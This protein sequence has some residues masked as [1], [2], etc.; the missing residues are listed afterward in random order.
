MKRFLALAIALLIIF[1]VQYNLD[2]GRKNPM[3]KFTSKMI[4]KTGAGLAV[5]GAVYRVKDFF[6]GA[7]PGVRDFISKKAKEMMKARWAPDPEKAITLHLTNGSA[8]S[9]EFVRETDKGYTIFWQ[10][11]EVTFYHDEIERVERGE[12]VEA[13]G[14]YLFDPEVAEEW[15]YK[16]TTAVIMTN[17]TAI[18]A[19]VT[20]VSEESVSVG[21]EVE[22]GGRIEQDLERKKVEY[23]LAKPVDNKLSRD[24]ERRLKELF[25]KMS[26]YKEGSTTIVTD[27]YITWVRE[28]R[29]TIRWAFRN[30][31]LRFFKLFKGRE[32][33]IQNFVVI[34]DDYND[35]V[36]YAVADGV[37]G[38]MVY[39]YFH[40]DD[41]ALYL[42]NFLGDKYADFLFEVLIGR[43]SDYINKQVDAYKEMTGGRY[44]HAIEGLGDEIKDK[45][46][47]YYNM[48]KADLGHRTIS[49]LRHEFAHEVF[50]NYGLQGV[51]L[52]KTRGQ[53]D[54]LTR[55]KKEFLETKD[56]EKKR[57]MLMDLIALAGRNADIEM[58]AANSWLSEGAA[59]Y[60]ETD[61]P[62]EES[63]L[64][65]FT[66]QKMKR[67]N[68]VYPIEHLT[69]YKI[70]SFP[71][72]YPEAMFYA[73]AQSWAL[74]TF[75]MDRYPEEFLR[76]QEKMASEKAEGQQD[77]SW[78]L[79]ETGKDVRTLQ[80]EFTAYMD[81]YDKL[82]DP[83][84]VT[85]EKLLNIFNEFRL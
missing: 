12:V 54:E 79:E 24:T 48:I 13:G 18:D 61:P 47:R 43:T 46:W 52:S 36:E 57:K 78:L 83:F 56:I 71:G 42:Y 64:W 67:E 40:P 37:P 41:K 9:G 85:Y 39:G 49:T 7:F 66:Y 4:A 27:S 84:A 11:G 60:C 82:E 75:L 51:I 63:K 33:Q 44:E 21:Y 81:G 68:A 35:F 59:T 29:T 15:P 69:L 38:W 45:I 77:I 17:G 14:E 6:A 8:I 30:I 62:G 25:P 20:D 74:F 72:M 50:S 70:G 10:D 26:F 22:G 3:N 2:C 1:A 31:Y 23:I 73:Y 5:D 80:D 34:F 58:Q 28:Y 55:K 76:Y 32:P 19:A 65:L 53:K 16:S